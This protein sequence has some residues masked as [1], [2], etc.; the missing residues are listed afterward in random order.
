MGGYT[1]EVQDRREEK[2]KAGARKCGE[3]RQEHRDIRGVE[4][5]YLKA[6]VSVRPN[7]L[8]EEAET[9]ISFR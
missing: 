7:G 2:K 4:G 9:E 1:T 5:R 6:K 8:R 3:R